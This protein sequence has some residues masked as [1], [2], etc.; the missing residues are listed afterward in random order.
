MSGISQIFRKEIDRIFKDKKLVFSVFILPIVVMVGIMTLVSNMSE[1]MMETIDQ[2]NSV[3]YIQH[4]PDGFVDFL[5][6]AD[7]GA[8]IRSYTDHA[9]ILAGIKAGDV[10]LFIEFPEHFLEEIKAFQTGSAIP[11]VKTYYNPSENFSAAAFHVISGTILENYRLSLLA[12]RVGDM[13]MLTVFTVNSDNPDMVVQDDTRAAGQMIG[14]MLPYFITILLFA[15]A[16]GIGT[17]MVAGEKER[18]TMASLLVAP[19]RRSSIV[20]GKVFS[21][22]VISGISS[23][24]YVLGMIFFMP[25]MFGGATGGATEGLSIS[26]TPLQMIQLALILV[27]LAFLYATIIILVSVFAKTIKEA[28]T[29]IMP[30]YMVILV[31]G[32][33]TMFNTGTVDTIYYFI[34]FYNTNVALQGILTQDITLYQF[35]ITLGVTLIMG[36]GLIVAIAKAFESEKVMAI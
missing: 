16:M 27:S 35:G 25:N 5:H 14:T 18:G 17:D 7:P 26:F 4:A 31:L 19:I 9:S 1:R 12:D 32:L 8:D 2:H 3:V 33:I 24:I 20:L 30:A 28:S 15:G 22:M 36:A 13:S 29:Y 34:P 10:D 21:L 11:Q 23:I 6:T